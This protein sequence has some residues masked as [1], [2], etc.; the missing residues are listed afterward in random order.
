MLEIL[1]GI[2]DGFSVGATEGSVD[3]T[4]DGKTEGLD[5]VP[6]PT[7]NTSDGL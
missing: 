6:A 2:S 5:V 1:L 4:T 3:K 7:M